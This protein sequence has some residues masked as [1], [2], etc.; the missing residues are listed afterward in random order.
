MRCLLARRRRMGGLD[1]STE[2][3]AHD[4]FP[5]DIEERHP[6]PVVE[7]IDDRDVRAAGG[8]AA[9]DQAHVDKCVA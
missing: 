5:Q 9:G 1:R 4:L 6:H 2:S 7:R 8:G 3:A